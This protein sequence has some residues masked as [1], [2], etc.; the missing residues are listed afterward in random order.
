MSN[1]DFAII[2]GTQANPNPY[3][4]D[5]EDVDARELRWMTDDMLDSLLA[6]HKE[7][8]RILFDVEDKD[9]FGYTQS[10]NFVIALSN[11]FTKPRDERDDFGLMM[12]ELLCEQLKPKA[13]A[14]AKESLQNAEED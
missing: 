9:S 12:R 2:H 14:M 6:N 3:E 10:T 7:I 1:P 4:L 8:Y 13:E 5:A 11:Y